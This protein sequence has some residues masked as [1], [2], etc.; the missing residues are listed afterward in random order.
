MASAQYCDSGAA[1]IACNTVLVIHGYTPYAADIPSRLRGTGAFTTVDT[2]DASSGTPTLSQLA[3]YHAVLMYGSGN[4][5]ADDTLMGDR[6]AAY[7]DQ[8]GGVVVMMFAM[9]NQSGYRLRGAYGT[10]SSGY[11]LTD[12]AQGNWIWP[13]DSLG[14]V[15]EPQSP[16]M[17]GV[18]Y[19][20]T[21]TA[22]RSI[23]PV[24]AGRGVVV[25]RWR[26]GGQEP[27]VLRGM[28][29]GRTLVELN[30][31]PV[32]ISTSAAGWS[33]DGAALLRN[34][35]KY[36]RCMPCGAGTYAAAGDAPPPHHHHH[37]R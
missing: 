22:Y 2:F 17:Q 1:I 27:L 4:P 10:V 26:G 33:G 5:F 14:D 15:L 11:A 35:L 32:S 9:C 18:G 28:R 19:F 30:F 34:G 7:H 16:L 12:Y 21:P 24:V 36:S 6:L 37:P 25:A 23:A 31:W 3:A 20:Y 29:G 8:G 13:P